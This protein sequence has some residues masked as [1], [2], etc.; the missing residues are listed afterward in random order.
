MWQLTNTVI[1]KGTLYLEVFN[2]LKERRDPQII[3]SFD[4]L[5]QFLLLWYYH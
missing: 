5:L 3:V 2:A 1:F 4:I